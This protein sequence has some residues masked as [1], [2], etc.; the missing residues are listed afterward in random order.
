MKKLLLI[1]AISTTLLSSIVSFAEENDF[2]VKVQAGAT[3]L[4]STKNKLFEGKMVAKAT[5]NFGVGAGYYV[6]D[7]VRADVTLDF[8]ANPQ[9][10]KSTG[11]SETANT[12]KHKGH[13]MSL[14][15]NGYVDVWDAEIV[16]LFAGVGAG[17]AQVKEKIHSIEGGTDK[18][19]GKTK[20]ANNFAYQLTVGVAG[21]AVE[22]VTA[23][24]SY[25]WKDNGK[26]KKIKEFPQLGNT[27]YRGHQVTFGIRFNI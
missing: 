12:V 3:F 10:K 25:S 14:L 13:V 8:L 21:E 27:A 20:K 22:G 7:N 19:L 9:F 2:Y 15:V 11:K 16:K 26:T 4:K 5:P 6:M 24:L 23:E 1:T 18:S 17:W